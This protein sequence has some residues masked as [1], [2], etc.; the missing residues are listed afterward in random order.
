MVAARNPFVVTFEPSFSFKGQ[1]RVHP[2]RFPAD[3]VF[4]E[5][6]DGRSV[7]EIHRKCSQSL[8]D[9]TMSGGVGLFV[10]VGTTSSG[11]ADTYKGFL[12]RT[13]EAVVAKCSAKRKS[14]FVSF[15][16]VRGSAV[17]DLMSTNS[18]MEVNITGLVV[19]LKVEQNQQI[20]EDTASGRLRGAEAIENKITSI[21][22]FTNLF[23]KVLRAKA[24]F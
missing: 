10:A 3:M 15:V 21:D 12:L 8:T 14:C 11:K 1:A 22:Q 13:V 17:T 2:L 7:V 6:E 23:Q 5:E 9:L 18:N 16:E 24:K 19:A 4:E 20:R